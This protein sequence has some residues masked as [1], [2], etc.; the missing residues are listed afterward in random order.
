MG[1]LLVVFTILALILILLSFSLF[2]KEGIFIKKKGGLNAIAIYI[3]LLTSISY[4]S[5]PSNYI[6][7]I[8]VSIFIGAIG[9]IGVFLSIYKS[10]YYDMGRILIL[11][12]MFFNFLMLF[13]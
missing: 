13:I 5:F 3:V 12:S 4:S 11:S 6:F 9:L 7:Q 10:N 2:Y 8:I 1:E